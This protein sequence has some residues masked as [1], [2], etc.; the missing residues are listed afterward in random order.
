MTTSTRRLAINRLKERRPLDA[1]TVDRFL[2]RYPGPIVEGRHCTFLFRG[3]A[4]EV[5]VRHRVTGLPDPLPLRRLR[6]VDLW[7]V[8]LELPE[9]SRVEY[10]LEI[11]RGETFERINDPLNPHRSHS[12]VG[13]SVTQILGP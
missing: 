7:S 5:W 13:S 1:A 3:E 9:G 12:P 6:G 4:D 8:V 11:R 10:Q 2:Q